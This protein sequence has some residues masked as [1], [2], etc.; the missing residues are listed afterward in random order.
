MRDRSI[1]SLKTH[2]RLEIG[3]DTS[4]NRNTLKI[5]EDAERG[6]ECPHHTAGY[7]FLELTLGRGGGEDCVSQA[8]C[9]ASIDWHSARTSMPRKPSGYLLSLAC[10]RASS[11]FAPAWLP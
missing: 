11:D 2:T 6:Q 4:P 1:G 3:S 10:D 8:V 5:H 7:D 9:H